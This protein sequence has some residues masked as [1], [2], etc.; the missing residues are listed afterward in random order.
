M[1]IAKTIIYSSLAFVLPIVF[2]VSISSALFK[3]GREVSASRDK[4]AA[5]VLADSQGQGLSKNTHQLGAEGDLSQEKGDI[6]LYSIENS[7]LLDPSDDRFFILSLKI[8][9]KE[10]PPIGSRQKIVSKYE[11]LKRPYAGWALA[12]NRQSTSTRPSFYFKDSKGKGG[13]F[14]FEAQDFEVGKPYRISVF[15]KPGEFIEMYLSET[16]EVENSLKLGAFSLSEIS[17]PKTSSNLIFGGTTSREDTFNGD[18]LDLILAKTESEE[19]FSS[20]KTL[21][22]EH[23]SVSSEIESEN[24]KLFLSSEKKDLSENTFKVSL[25]KQ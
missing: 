3:E 18:V 25:L 22:V 7:N 12:L 13:W 4:I 1:T 24:I 11:T 14:A 16:D 20:F 5:E 19:S 2:A 17:S 9:F 6:L 15:A 8:I 21:S 23:Q 10:L